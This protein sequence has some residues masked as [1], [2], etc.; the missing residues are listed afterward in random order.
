MAS[1]VDR[2][3]VA[4]GAADLDEL[5]ALLAPDVTWGAPGAD[6]PAWGCHNRRQ[7]IEWY[8][9]G[10]DAGVR[11]DVSDVARHGDKI[12]VAMRVVRSEAEG[13]TDRWQVLTIRDELVADIRG[14]ETLADA[15]AAAGASR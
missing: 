11:A 12:L 8:R 1:L 3:R 15:R 13:P 5:G 6:D 7:V 9:R 14:F 2:I 4:L 10:R